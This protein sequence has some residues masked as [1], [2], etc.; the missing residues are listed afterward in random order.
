MVQNLHFWAPCRVSLTRDFWRRSKST[1]APK[2]PSEAGAAASG[3]NPADFRHIADPR[4]FLGRRIKP[5]AQKAGCKL[6]FG[7]GRF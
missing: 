4:D 3:E 5:P 2:V 1:G 6:G 7:S